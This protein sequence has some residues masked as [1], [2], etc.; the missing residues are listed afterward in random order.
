M[1]SLLPYIPI[2]FRLKSAK[3]KKMFLCDIFKIVLL[4][5]KTVFINLKKGM[6]ELGVWFA[7]KQTTHICT[8]FDKTNF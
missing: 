3:K 2:F 8:T 7:A 4:P 6:S 5:M 1:F